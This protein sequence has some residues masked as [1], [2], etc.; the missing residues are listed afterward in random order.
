MKPYLLC[1]VVF[2]LKMIPLWGGTAKVCADCNQASITDAIRSAK[3]G[4]TILIGRGEYHEGTIVIDKPLTLKGEPG[5]VLDGDNKVE[6]LIIDSD[7]V[8]VEGLTLRNVGRSSIKDYAAIRVRR[9]R[10]FTIRNNYVENAFFGIYLEYADDG[11]VEHNI[12]TGDAK[13]ELTSGN[14]IHAW[15][16][17]RIIIRDNVVTGHRDGVYFEFVDSSYI[18]CN[19]SIG[20]VRYGLHFM[21]SN[22]DSY[23]ENMFQSNGAGV[24]VMFSKRIAMR[25][26]RFE[27]NWGRSSYGLLLKEIYDATI[28][29]NTFKKN[30]VGIFLEGA[31]RILYTHNV[32]EGN[33]WAFK[34]T[35]G[36]LDNVVTANNFTG[37]TLDLVMDNQLNNN[38]FDGNYWSEYTGY[39][40]NRDG[41]GDV[42]F[43]PVKLY[44]FILSK[45]PE[46]IILL[47]SLF[48]NLLNFS[49]KVSPVFTPVNVLDHR[50]QMHAL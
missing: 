34:M 29:E 3:P 47:R 15:Y 39:D 2:L 32:F 8:T 41:V 26:N 12:V 18:A 24:A 5:V 11:V 7:G 1:L 25:C 27:N 10:H 42:P 45:T 4:D 6:I 16:C 46:T 17:H 9:H 14:A 48:I 13:D 35:G 31:T 44:S 21:F 33:G 30:T 22:D 37:N 43:R 49:E 20:N 23:E 19:Q 50:P 36:C 40:L 38:T 28:E